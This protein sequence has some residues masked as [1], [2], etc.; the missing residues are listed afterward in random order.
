MFVIYLNV[1]ALMLNIFGNDSFLLDVHAL[2]LMDDTVLLAS[3]RKNVIKKFTILMEFC[4]KYGMKVNELKTN[5]M[6]INGTAND[7]KEFKVDEVIVKHTT[8]YVYLGSPFTED[9]NINNVIKLHVK[10]RTADV[11]KFK[12]FCRKN[13]TMPYRL[14][15]QVLMAMI[16]SSLLYASETWLT[17]NVKDVEKM[18]LSCIKALLGVRETTRSDTV[19]IES[20]M[21]S[22]SDMIRKRTL[23][24]TKKELLVE[25]NDKTPL[26]KIY[27][28]CE[29][30]QSRGYRYLK[31][32]MLPEEA[33]SETSPSLTE[34]FKSESGSKAITYRSIN[35]ELKVH[36]IYYSKEYI[37]ERARL[38]VRG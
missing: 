31:N 13:E 24:F 23:A 7:R 25:T 36:P 15:K 2:M 14:K 29:E 3:S 16:V 26:Q 35:P 11:N 20:G 37:D 19:L 30:K 9:A 10:S 8:S 17:T 6:V 21:S 4:K 38:T 18:Y 22:V 1:L 27:K 33:R 12:I 28:I 34:S 32:L 5:I